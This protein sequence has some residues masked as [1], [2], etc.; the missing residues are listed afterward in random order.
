MAPRPAFCEKCGHPECLPVFGPDSRWCAYC[1]DELPCPQAKGFPVTQLR[2]ELNPRK[3]IP[4]KNKCGRMTY[5][6]NCTGIC[7]ECKMSRRAMREIETTGMDSLSR[8]YSFR[9]T[10]YAMNTLLL[11]KG[12]Y[13]PLEFGTLFA[14]WAKKESRKR[15]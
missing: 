5:R 2:Q 4:C 8:E 7:T 1:E 3:S 11:Q 14:E 12:V 9:A 13:S 15:A 10:V 6:K